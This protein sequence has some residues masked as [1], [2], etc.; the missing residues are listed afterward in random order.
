M[1]IADT[2]TSPVRVNSIAKLSRWAWVDWVS[3]SKL[4]L[5]PE[6]THPPPGGTTAAADMNL[7]HSS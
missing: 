1:A 6:S 2:N 7:A 4:I 5:R 3:F